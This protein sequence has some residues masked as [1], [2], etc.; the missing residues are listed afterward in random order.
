M[1][2]VSLLE[3][4]IIRKEQVDENVMEIDAVDSKK[5]EVEV[6]WDSAIHAEESKSDQ[7]LGLYYLVI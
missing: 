5:Y 3:Q 4:D 6:I 2:Y 1:F 7:L